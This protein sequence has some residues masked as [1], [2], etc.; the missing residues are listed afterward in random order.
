MCAADSDVCYKSPLQGYECQLIAPANGREKFALV[1]VLLLS[2]V[3]LI[4]VNG[5]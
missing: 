3:L 4:W 2:A 1:L 5:L